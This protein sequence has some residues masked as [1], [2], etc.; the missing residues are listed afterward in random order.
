MGEPRP[1]DRIEL[2]V[3]ASTDQTRPVENKWLKRL[4]IATQLELSFFQLNFEL[5]LS[6]L[7]L[8]LTCVHHT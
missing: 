8:S 5:H 7:V 1:V 4:R 2:T 3:T 6:Y